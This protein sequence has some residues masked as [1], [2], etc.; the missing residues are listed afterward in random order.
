MMRAQ[1]CSQSR[2]NESEGYTGEIIKLL[3][4]SG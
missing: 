4:N 3:S 2:L 1:N